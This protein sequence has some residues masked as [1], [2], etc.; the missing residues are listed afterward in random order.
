METAL[1][2][3]VLLESFFKM[4]MHIPFSHSQEAFKTNAA[5]RRTDD[6]P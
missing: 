3:N 6:V 4:N 1:E 2:A 5:K